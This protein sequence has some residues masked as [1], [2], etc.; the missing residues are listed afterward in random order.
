MSRLINELLASAYPGRNPRD[1]TLEIGE[2]VEQNGRK[3]IFMSDP[4]FATEYETIKDEIARARRPGYVEE[5]KGAFGSAVDDLQATG[6]GLGALAAHGAKAIGI[7]GA[8]PIRNNFLALMKEEQAQAA[9]YQPS[10]P[11]YDKITNAEDAARYATYGLG[12]V[13]PS[14]VQAAASGVAGA[15]L[16]SAVGPGGAVGGA[17]L[18]LAERRLAQKVLSGWLA[19]G[20]TTES[21]EVAAKTLTRAEIAGEAK[22]LAIQYGGQAALAASSIGQEVGSI[23]SENPEAPGTAL[24]YGIP[25]GLLDVLPEAYIAS[26]FLG[27]G[28]RVAEAEVKQSVGYFR[29][30][31]QEAAKVVPLEG[32]TEAAQTL[33]EIAAAKSGRGEDP[34]SFTAADYKQM[35]NAGIIGAI[36]GLGM[37]PV[38]A[39]GNPDARVDPTAQLTSDAMVERLPARQ[40]AETPGT[41]AFGQGNDLLEGDLGLIEPPRPG[42]PVAPVPDAMAGIGEVEI[43]DEG[44]DPF[45]RARPAFRSAE[46][47]AQ[48]EEDPAL[49]RGVLYGEPPST[50]ASYGAGFGGA[51]EMARGVTPQPQA[52]AAPAAPGIEPSKAVT[53]TVENVQEALRAVETAQ[54]GIEQPAVVF[55]TPTVVAPPVAAPEAAPAVKES[56]TVETPVAPPLVSKA[57][58]PVVEVVE[59]A[60]PIIAPPPV[61][62]DTAAP[63]QGSNILPA[64]TTPPV[65]TGIPLPVIQPTGVVTQPTVEQVIVRGENGVKPLPR[66]SAPNLRRLQVFEQPRASAPVEGQENEPASIRPIESG[67]LGPNPMVEL[68][69]RVKKAT[70]ADSNVAVVIVDNQ[71]G[72]AFQRL[73]YGG[74]SNTVYIDMASSREPNKKS[75]GTIQGS[76]TSMTADFVNGTEGRPISGQRGIFAETMPNGIPRYTVYGIGELAKPGKLA[77]WNLG[78]V[79]GLAQH[80]GISEAAKRGWTEQAQAVNSAKDELPAVP[81]IKN[82]SEESGEALLRFSDSMAAWSARHRSAADKAKARARIDEFATAVAKALG[83][84]SN[85]KAYAEAIKAQIN[86]QADIALKQSVL[87]SDDYTVP[88]ASTNYL[89]QSTLR[90]LTEGRKV[91]VVAFEQGLFGALDAASQTTGLVINGANRRPI[92]AFASSALNGPVRPD[93]V[94]SLLHEVG[95]V[96][97]DGLA[98]PLRVAFQESINDMPWQ[99][100]GWLL[101]PRSLDIRLLA[102][103]DPL[104]LSP[105]QRAAL[106]RLTPEEIAAARRIDPAALLEEKMAEHLAQLGWD[107]SEAKG[108]VQAMIRFVK[109]LW[110]RMAMAIQ[111]ALKGAENLSPTL[112]RAYMEN[113]FLQFIHRDS[114]LASDRIHDLMNWLGVP[115]TDAQKIPVFPAGADWDQRMTYIDVATGEIIPVKTGNYTPDAQTRELKLSLDSAA[116]WVAEHPA[117]STPD[118]PDLRFTQRANFSAP[119]SS[120]PTVT[121]NGQFAR[122]NLEDQIYRQIAA[123][124]EIAP[125]LPIRDGEPPT[126]QAFA[127]DWLKLP[128][129]Q[130]PESRKKQAVASAA[131]PDPLTGQPIAHEPDITIDDLPTVEQKITDRDGKPRV[132]QIT[133]AQDDAIK[134]AL[135]SMRDTYR[136]VTAQL[137]R[138][139]ARYDQLTA[140][141]AKEG[142]TRGEFTAAAQYELS[143]LGEKVL[144]RQRIALRLDREINALLAKFQP[145]DIVQVFPGAEMLSVPTADASEEHIRTA[146]KYKL[147]LQFAFATSDERSA[148]GDEIS[149]GEA[150]LKN[151]ENRFQGQIYGVISEQVRKLRQIPLDQERAAVSV[152]L[153]KLS[154]GFIGNLNAIGLPSTRLLA[155]KF[156]GVNAFV[157]QYTSDLTTMGRRWETAFGRFAEAMGR[158]MDGAFVEEFWD[159]LSRIWNFLDSS[160]RAKLGT[161]DEGSIFTSM[162]R[163]L[164][165]QTGFEVKGEKQREAL[166]AVMMQSIERERYFRQIFEQHPELKVYDK[167][168]KSYRRL[169]THGMV[170]GSRGLRREMGSLALRMNP[171]WSDTTGIGPEDQRSF[172]EAAGDLYRTD[173]AAFDARMAKL[174]D[175]YVA[176]DFVAPLATNNTPLFSVIGSDGQAQRASILNVRRAWSEAGNDVTKFAEILHQLE[177]APE[178]MEGQTVGLVLGSL[179]ERFGALKS[180]LDKQAAAANSGVETLQR[181]MLD[182]REANDLPA[183]WVSYGT[184][185]HISNL[186]LLHQLG[187]Q[188]QFGPDGM[189]P[190]K[191]SALG[192]RRSADGADQISAGGELAE[193][194]YAAKRELTDIRGRFDVLDRDGLSRKQ[195]DSEMG[196]DDANIARNYDRSVADLTRVETLFNQMRSV[197]NY[198]NTD[199]KAANDLLGLASTMM[200]QNPRSGVQQVA[201]ILGMIVDLKMSTQ[202]LRGLR[203]AVKTTAGQI[204]NSVLESFGQQAAFGVDAAQRRLR[205]GSRDSETRVGWTE[206]TQGMGP[207]NQLGVPVGYETKGDFI[208]RSISRITRRAREIIPAAGSPFAQPSDER[209]GPKLTAGVFHTFTRAAMDA[210]TTAAYDL[211]ADI[212]GRGVEFLQR[213]PAK[214][215]AQFV[216]EL[217]LGVRDLGAHELGYYGG[218]LLND[219]AAFDSLKA[220]LETQM[221]GERSV[222]DFVA[223]AYRRMEAAQD[224]AAAGRGDGAWD[225]ISDSQFVDIANYAASQWTLHPNFATL[226]AFMQG[227]FKPLF[228]FLTWPYLAMRRAAAGFTDAQQ[229]MTWAGAN[230][231]VADGAKAFF[232][233]AAPA[234]IAGSFAIDWYDEYVSGK[235]QNLRKAPASTAI[236][237][238]GAALH[239]AAFVERWARYGTAGLPSEI[240]NM[241]VNYDSQRGLSLDNRVVAFNAIGGLFNTLIKT[242]IQTEANLTYASF[243]RPLLQAIGGGGVLHYLQVA[244]NLLGLNTQDAAINARINTGNYLRAAGKELDLPVAVF[245]GPSSIPTP[246]SPY[247]QQMELAALVNNAD[248]FRTAY[249][250]AVQAARDNGHRE[251][252]EKYVANNFA[253]RHPLKRLFKGAVSESDYRKM[254]GEMGEY[255]AGKVR[256]SINSFNKYMTNWFG[257]KPY[258]GKADRGGDS[259]EELIRRATRINSDL[260]RTE[261]SLLA[262]P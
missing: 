238:L 140:D 213:I 196:T 243:G 237:L 35:V 41:M 121:L 16:G 31:A 197:T 251:D 249:R 152:I 51:A 130:T 27:A 146:R 74:P 131:Q 42:L 171:L 247:L 77:N 8:E 156:A 87:I 109:E 19:K 53:K 191:S 138:D 260:D 55:P 203:S 174:F 25:A 128:A 113:R 4:D 97:T 57:P 106:E 168:L 126:A 49:D 204:G 180:I 17:L 33:L 144:L 175:G 188:S 155:K 5:F 32:S 23:Y 95:H 242:P 89:F 230:S 58:M 122:I 261:D 179:R 141:K 61:A 169:F 100:S 195:I 181:Q 75:Y 157:A 248:L 246:I 101:N 66:D 172:W 56:L 6:Y 40:N 99:Q 104:Q 137:G 252:A 115:A 190:A 159:P 111:T 222:G 127:T 22:R 143:D 256:E 241:A 240:L 134:Q 54:T 79:A 239:P 211:F 192:D 206:K 13:A 217:E 254:L 80:P 68:V 11:S 39:I 96:V 220:G 34:T 92:V 227:P 218:W 149:R 14:M 47:F 162:E 182:G 233:V 244:Q 185:D 231:S 107:K 223:K 103:A 124:S 81:K 221:S 110:L 114:A 120:T 117:G 135:L 148:I 62:T 210:N 45:Q 228:V 189:A 187:M 163:E 161:A 229:R 173:R 86:R 63:P 21:L 71:T 72:Q 69:K 136:R 165:A 194:I 3:D 166:R 48:N 116:R 38:S 170:T 83:D 108:A 78:T 235:K 139:K 9:E 60:A 199:L 219:R 225:V 52:P 151:P 255:G 73:A 30:F 145:G 186:T 2:W 234:T 105:E 43:A 207:R 12:T 59:P 201:D 150:W 98:E 253:E 15:A 70:K 90:A 183:Q 7:P 177:G 142:R 214:D 178:G 50:A 46:V 236:P 224:E 184:M 26:R 129:E 193:T 64:G 36:G 154:G 123:D 153:R 10:V 67:A 82:A 20:I 215:R 29:R 1:L 226:P 257:K 208:G 24:A 205:I 132:V 18:G 212:A 176:D 202:T 216:R 147:P 232:L 76:T 164:K 85:A 118:T 84:T 198:L 93:T 125:L 250:S 37:A 102:N 262:V 160:E 209:L 133:E 158:P 259:V 65:A 258:F 112:A 245:S 88:T 28:K 94:L 200:L 167:E 44:F 91:D 119:F